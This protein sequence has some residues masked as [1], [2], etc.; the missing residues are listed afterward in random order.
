[1]PETNFYKLRN[2]DCYHNNPEC[3]SFKRSI[4]GDIEPFCFD[5]KLFPNLHYCGNCTPPQQKDLKTTVLEHS[6]LIVFIDTEGV[7]NFIHQFA[8]VFDDGDCFSK[9]KQYSEDSAQWLKQV[10]NDFKIIVD[11]KANSRRVI[12]VMQNPLHDLNLIK[13]CF[14][15]H[16]MNLRSSNPFPKDWLCADSIDVFRN[17]SNNLKDYK[18]KTVIDHAFKRKKY[19]RLKKLFTPLLQG[20]NEKDLLRNMSANPKLHTAVVDA[21]MLYLL[22]NGQ[23]DEICR[24]TFNA[25]DMKKASFIQSKEILGGTDYCINT[26]YA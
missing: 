22:L 6:S 24:V 14:P 1:M 21:G 2:R 19:E 7:N 16:K 26:L 3:R 4:K 18:L 12:L 15:R 23:A 25:R 5:A 20:N 13:D 17:L 9:Y 10:W 11:K 8:A